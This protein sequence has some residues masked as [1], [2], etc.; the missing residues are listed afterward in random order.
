MDNEGNWYG[1][2]ESITGDEGMVTMAKEYDS[3][4]AAIKG[5]FDAK[6]LV[7][8]PF[9]LPE[10]LDK[11]PDDASRNDFKAGAH[12]LLGTTPAIGN[13]EELADI[14]LK[15]GMTVG[16]E[17]EVN[18]NL[19]TMLKTIAVEKKWPKSVVQDVVALYNGPLT[20][21]SKEFAAT[22]AENKKIADAK[23]TDEALIAHP[24]IGSKEKLAELSEL[25]RRAVKNNVGLTAEE[26]EEFGEV[27]ADT[28]LTKN[29]VMAR[30][31]LK[32]LAPLAAEGTTKTG[33]DVGKGPKKELD[34][35][36]GIPATS[37][38]LGWDE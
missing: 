36:A 5:G 12:K 20:K 22:Q 10:T 31:M 16:S 34:K 21:F 6:K 25:L 28:M 23:A 2:M 18:E 8:R 9:K 30:V 29:K 13:I 15:A 24:D 4:E 32:V 38:A 17:T 3:A 7:G 27:M 33:T 1:E 19:T 14:D 11:L 26:Y 37:K 35:E